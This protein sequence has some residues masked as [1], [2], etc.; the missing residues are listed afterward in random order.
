MPRR[1]TVN[2]LRNACAGGCR[3]PLGSARRTDVERTAGHY[4]R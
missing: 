2:I 3:I 4:S 1:A